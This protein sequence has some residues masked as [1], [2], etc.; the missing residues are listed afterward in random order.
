MTAILKVTPLLLI[1]SWT[2][3]SWRFLAAM[4]VRW[5]MNAPAKSQEDRGSRIVVCSGQIMEHSIHKLYRGIRTTTFE[6]QHAQGQ[7]SNKF[8]C[9]ANFECDAWLWQ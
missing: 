8:G 9:F 6:P 2:P 7:L 4:T 5:L 1:C 3:L